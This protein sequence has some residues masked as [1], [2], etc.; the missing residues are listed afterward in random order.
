MKDP[1]KKKLF[2]QVEE[3]AKQYFKNYKAQ[4]IMQMRNLG[5]MNKREALAI[6]KQMQS[7]QI[8]LLRNLYENI[9]KSQRAE[10]YQLIEPMLQDT[11]FMRTGVDTDSLEIVFTLQKLHE[12]P[13]FKEMIEQGK[14]AYQKIQEEAKERGRF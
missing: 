13:E 11:L 9:P 1:Q 4:M 12:D 8:D 7:I 2:V 14:M 5:Q 3:S 6:Q 10:E